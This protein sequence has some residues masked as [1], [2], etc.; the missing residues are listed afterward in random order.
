MLGRVVI[1]AGAAAMIWMAGA[2]RVVGDARLPLGAIVKGSV[3]TQPFGCTSFALEPVDTAC[4]GGH[5]HSGVDLAAW[6]GTPVLA[7]VSGSANVAF[8][9]AGCGLFVSVVNRDHVRVLY[10]HLSATRVRSG[11]EVMAGDVVGEVGASG[12]ATGPHVHFEVQ[13]DGLPID[14][15]VWLRP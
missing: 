5:F 10:C 3:M 7:A 8:D 4:P 11:T 1:V 15:A 12:L 14:P 9:P 13:V 2:A 6:L